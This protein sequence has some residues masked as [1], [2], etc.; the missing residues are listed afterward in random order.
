MDAAEIREH[1]QAD[2]D[3]RVGVEVLGSAAD[4]AEPVRIDSPIVAEALLQP[5]QPRRGASDRLPVAREGAVKGQRQAGDCLR[6][7]LG[8]GQ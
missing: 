3:H 1:V 2:N 6:V 8:R 4:R 5:R 7:R